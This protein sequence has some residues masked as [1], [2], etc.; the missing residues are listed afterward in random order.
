MGTVVLVPMLTIDFCINC[1]RGG[2]VRLLYVQVRPF[3]EEARVIKN[4]L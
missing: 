3:F 4:Y 2:D 1:G